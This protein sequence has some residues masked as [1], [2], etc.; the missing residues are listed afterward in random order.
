MPAGAF[1]A[2]FLPSR[3]NGECDGY[4]VVAKGTELPD[5]ENMAADPN[6]LA[7]MQWDETTE[8][9]Q[10]S[11]EFSLES[12]GKVTMGFVVSAPVDSRVQI[13]SVSLAK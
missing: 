9:V 11:M 4:F 2:G 6:V 1:N 13:R 7:F 10:Q 3:F 5:A 8:I 12:A